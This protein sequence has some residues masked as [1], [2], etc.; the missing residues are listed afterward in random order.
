MKE[1]EKKLD[2]LFKKITKELKSIPEEK[3][4]LDKAS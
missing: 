3:T 4:P 1:D 2:Q